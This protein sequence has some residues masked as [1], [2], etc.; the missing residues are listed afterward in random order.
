MLRLKASGKWSFQLLDAAE[1]VMNGTTATNSAPET[2]VSFF[3]SAISAKD[4]MKFLAAE[5]Q[6][7]L[8]HFFY[9]F[10]IDLNIFSC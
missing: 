8:L 9:F 7:E 4:Q 3:F 2:F 1:N 5:V 10:L 6:W